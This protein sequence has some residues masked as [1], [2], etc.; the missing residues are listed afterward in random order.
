MR[1]LHT[2]GSSTVRDERPRF[3]ASAV[4]LALSILLPVLAASPAAAAPL[5]SDGFE[6]GDMSSWTGST[7]IVV[8]QAEVH[9]GTW[10]ARATSTGSPSWA[11]RS[12]GSAQDELF[13]RT[14]FKLISNSTNVFLVRVRTGAGSI[15]ASLGVNSGGRLFWRDDVAGA[16]TTSA[17]NVTRGV[18]HEAQMRVLVNG[19]SS[20]AEVWIDGVRIDDLS[21]SKSL[22][23]TLLG[24]I[25]IGDNSSSRTYD[26]VFD[27]VVADVAFIGGPPDTT[28]PSAPTGLVAT[29][30]APDR[31]Q[32]SWS[33]PPETDV[34]GYTIYRDGA[35]V[36]TVSGAAN[37]TFED[38]TVSPETTYSYAVDAFDGATPPNHS[39]RSSPA[40]VTTPPG[41]GGADPVVAGAGDIACDPASGAYRGGNGTAS[42]CHMKHTADVLE[43]LLATTDLHNILALGDDQ[44]ECGGLQAFNTSYAQSWGRPELKAITRPVPGDEE[45]NTSG[46]TDCSTNAAGYFAYFGAAAGDPSKGYYSFDVGAWHVIALNSQCAFVGG[47]DAGSAQYRFLQTDLETHPTACTLAFWHKPRFGSGKGGG[48][49][50]VAPFWKLLHGAGAEIV[51]NG[52]HHIY[53]RFAPQTPSQQASANGIRQFTVGTG[54]KSHAVF[55]TIAPN[56]QVRNNDTYGV[57]TLTLHLTSYDW[58]FVPEA[59]KTF[60]DSGSTACH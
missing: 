53:E 32:L 14:W 20:Q 60:T 57:L 4:A 30:T 5:F 1:G 40:V 19:T 29:A 56:S 7:G 45:Y 10:A 13:V 50:K 15:V 25:Q 55:G 18:W 31:V 28:P 41:Q 43:N 21:G 39:P 9:S 48:T 3:R 59:G 2:A 54:G 22:G 8:Q 38:G 17:T 49:S 36:G 6:S 37:T 24:R 35:E 27:D 42:N 11:Y 51:L 44:Y 26:V 12:L 47:C 58:R 52:H 23:T 16:N 46:G 34:A 33:A